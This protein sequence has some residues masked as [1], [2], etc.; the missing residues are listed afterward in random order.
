MDSG[1]IFVIVLTV[2]FVGGLAWLEVHSRRNKTESKGDGN[3]PTPVGVRKDKV[4][5]LKPRERR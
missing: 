2:I 5:P 4:S 1:I 3:G